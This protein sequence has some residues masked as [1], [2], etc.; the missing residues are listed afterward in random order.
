MGDWGLIIALLSTLL[1]LYSYVGYP[2]LLHYLD[3]KKGKSA[4]QQSFIENG[5]FHLSVLMSVYNE[6]LVLPSKLETLRQQDCGRHS[7]SIYIGSDAST[8]GSNAILE[9][10]VG[11]GQNR[12][13]YEGK[14]RKGKAGVMHE[15]VKM[16]TAQNQV[17]ENHL[18]VMTD[19]SVL[20]SSDVLKRL[21]DHFCDPCIGLVDSHMVHTGMKEGNISG[22]ENTYISGEVRV[23]HL[24]G[25]LW[26]SM[27]GP[28]GGCFAL[29]SDYYSPVPPNFLVDDFFL[30][31]K[32][33][34]KGG[35]TI[36]DLNAVCHEEVSQKIE[37]EFR[38]KA[39]I[40]AGNFQNMSYFKHLWWPPVNWTAFAFISHKILR[41]LGPFFLGGILLGSFFMGLYGN[42]FQRGLF[43]L[44][45]FVFFGP[46]LLHLGLKRFGIY[47][48][49]LTDVHY[50]LWMHLALLKG[51]LNYLY[52]IKSNIWRPTS[53]DQHKS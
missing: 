2:F 26:R 22:S 34:E 14:E 40:A 13:F 46:P 12:H 30:C 4:P 47:N 28:F 20:L 15:L 27:M 35:G 52:G 49:L 37:E 6:A 19:A 42:K 44:S 33:L 3:L 9:E 36:S 21:A 51:F 29:R 23:K 31:M 25:K 43:F 16:A 1:M 50:F 45:L 7:C 24:E 17:G 5:K 10:W 53:R 8:D 11:E 32:V 39:R 18:F 48:K 41:W 38:R